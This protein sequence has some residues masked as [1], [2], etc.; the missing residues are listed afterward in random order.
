MNQELNFE[1][2]PWKL[3][4][5]ERIDYIEGH[6][7][8]YDGNL[9]DGTYLEWDFSGNC[10]NKNKNFDIMESLLNWKYLRYHGYE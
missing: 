7:D 9:E 10:T 2:G 1:G 3:R 5:G 6:Q 8:N 4:N